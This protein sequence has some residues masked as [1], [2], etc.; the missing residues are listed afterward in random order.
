VAQVKKKN[1]HDWHPTNQFFPLAIEILDVYTNKLMCFTWLCQCHMELERAKRPSF[2]YLG[3]FLLSKKFNHIAKGVN[4]FH[5][6]LGN[7][8]RLPNFHPLRTH[9]PSPWLTLLQVI[10]FWHGKTW[11]NNYK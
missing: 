11:P 4:I 7:S 2:F 8:C 5:L 1:Y 3:Y 10:D 9:L 6:K